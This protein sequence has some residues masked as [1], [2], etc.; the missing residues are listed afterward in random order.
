V[1]FN[2]LLLV[3]VIHGC[4]GGRLMAALPEHLEVGRN[5][6]PRLTHA[7]ALAELT[8]RLDD[9]MPRSMVGLLAAAGA[10]VLALVGLAHGLVLLLALVDGAAAVGLA[11]YV[12]A[13]GLPPSPER[14]VLVI[15]K[16][17]RSSR[18]DHL[19]L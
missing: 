7:R 4:G 13:P 19:I 1:P 3:E 9:L 14:P 12:T 10:A 6:S 17:F 2:V 15:K 8:Y 11:A 18:F 5:L 16:I